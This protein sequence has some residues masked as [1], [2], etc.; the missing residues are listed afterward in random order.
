MNNGLWY[1]NFVLL[2]IYYFVMLSRVRFLVAVP[3]E[4]LSQAPDLPTGEDSF[5]SVYCFRMSCG[6]PEIF[7]TNNDDL[8][9][10]CRKGGTPLQG[11]KSGLLSNT[12]KKI[13]GGDMCWQS[14]RFYWERAPRWR[15]VK[16]TQENSSAMWLVVLGFMV[17]GLVSRWS[18]ANH[19]DSES[20]LVPHALLSKDGCSQEGF[21]EVGGHVVS[22]FDLSWTLLVGSG[23]LVP[24]SLPGPPVVKQPMQMVIREPGQGGR[25]QSVCFP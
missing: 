10:C 3:N 17:M 25:F 22:P 19:S 21:W 23:L 1:L 8:Q 24:Y 14:K 15:A 18:L 11:P 16:G 2:W 12:W 7:M 4:T 6:P 9:Y 13:V 20:F 5:C